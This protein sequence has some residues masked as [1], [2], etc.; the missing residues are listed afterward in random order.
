MSTISFPQGFDST[1]QLAG[2]CNTT[3]LCFLWPSVLIRLKA[4][5]LIG[6]CYHSLSQ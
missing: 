6:C 2:R 4:C 3:R 1:M 5:R